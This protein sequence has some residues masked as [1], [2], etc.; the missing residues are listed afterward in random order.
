MVAFT[1]L[2]RLD[3]V[4]YLGYLYRKRNKKVYSVV[5]KNEDLR[6]MWGKRYLKW[7]N[8]CH[9]SYF[10]FIW[11]K[12]FHVRYTGWTEVKTLFLME[13]KAR[14]P[15]NWWKSYEIIHRHR[16]SSFTITVPSL[17]PL[18][19]VYFCVYVVSIFTKIPLLS[20]KQSLLHCLSRVLLMF[21]SP[22]DVI[23][24][25]DQFHWPISPN[26]INCFLSLNAHRL[27]VSLSGYC[28]LLLY[29]LS[30]V[31]FPL[32]FFLLYCYVALLPN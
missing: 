14:E 5:G 1:L 25:S 24:R 2:W 4:P 12:S 30:K 18:F 10:Y 28:I 6:Q 8:Q 21:H 32:V 16:I 20:F 3:S 19:L 15:D 9:N 11:E 17:L 22:L 23:S 13:K 7:Q 29:L 26:P 31:W 27:T